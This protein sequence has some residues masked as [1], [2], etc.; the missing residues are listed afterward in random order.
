MPFLIPVA[1]AIF[2]TA[3]VKAVATYAIRAL[4]VAGINRLA[5]DLLAP[6]QKQ[7]E[8]QAS[9]TTLSLGERPREAVFGRALVG[10]SL[11]WAWN[12][13]GKYGTD[14][15]VVVIQVADHLCDGLE[16]FYVE[17]QFYAYTADGAHSGFVHN[18]QSQLSVYW[19]PGSASQTFPAH[20]Q[21]SGG[22]TNDDLKGVA[23]L[24]FDYLYIADSQVFPSGRP[25]FKALVRGKRLYDPRKDSTVT[26]GSGAHRW[27]SP[28]TWEWSENAYLCRYNWARGVYALDLVDQPQHLLIGRGL[29][30]AEAPPERALAPANLCDEAVP[31]KAGG[32]EKRYR[33][34][35]VINADEQFIVVEEMFAAAMAGEIIQPEGTVDIAPGEAKASVA[36]IT[37]DDLV[38]GATVLWSDFEAQPDRVNSIIPTYVEPTQNWRS[39]AAPIRRSL[40][41]ISDDGGPHEESLDLALVTSGTQA[42]RCGEIRRRRKRRERRRTITLPPWFSH[43]EEGDWI[44]W[45]SARFDGGA[46]R[47]WQI[48]RHALAP[49]RQLTVQLV[50]IAASDFAWT[51]ASDEVTPGTPLPAASTPPDPLELDNV[52]V[53]PVSI[54]GVPGLRFTWDTPVDASVRAIRAEVRVDGQ[55]E[56]SPTITLDVQSGVMDVTAGVAGDLAMQ[57]RL[58]PQG[59]AD[60]AVAPSLW[61]D[62]TPPQAELDLATDGLRVWDGTAYRELVEIA[63]GQLALTEDLVVTES[64]NLGAVKKI[65][66][67]QSVGSVTIISRGSPSGHVLIKSLT[68]DVEDSS[69]K[70]TVTVSFQ[71]KSFNANESFCWLK[72]GQDAPVWATSGAANMTNADKTFYATA[73][74]GPVTAIYTFTGLPV[75]TNTL[76]VHAGSTGSGSHI[77]TATDTYFKVE[78]D[79]RTS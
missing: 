68:F 60:R 38:A 65:S 30:A 55:T 48:I 70:I 42:Q 71:Y 62:V 14:H 76:E 23:Y 29:T 26:G 43:L 4:V 73:F 15:E 5:T 37:D 33:A 2:T 13:G 45:T 44:T 7:A 66:A 58:V 54:G 75:G 10:G 32:T 39:H 56:T 41:D 69:A 74:S 3:T 19:R 72:I 18:G 34:G 1:T 9:I 21:A 50:E 79:K 25:T 27:N 47:T 64:V 20:L 6:K 22:F 31:L 57:G 77:N 53:A 49:G 8:R 61:I 35:G 67:D 17:D 59:L 36:S 12:Y 24:V 16:G 11:L 46:S 40:T 52:A 63:G 78:E 28:G 51:A